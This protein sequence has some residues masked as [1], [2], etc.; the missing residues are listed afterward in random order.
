MSA[1]FASLSAD[2]IDACFE[3]L[4]D[5]LGVS[6]HLICGLVIENG[7]SGNFVVST[8][9]HDENSRG[10]KFLDNPLGRNTDS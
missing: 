6:N 5:V 9:V 3:G 1:S 8:Y 4:S 2:E 7:D 10:V